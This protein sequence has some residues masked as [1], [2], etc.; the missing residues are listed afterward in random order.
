MHVHI[1]TDKGSYAITDA[2]YIGNIHYVHTAI[3]IIIRRQNRSETG[4]PGMTMQS[5][6]THEI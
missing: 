3:K 4:L 1:H 6:P 5:A 2:N